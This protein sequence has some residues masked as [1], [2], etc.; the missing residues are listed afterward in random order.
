MAPAQAFFA[1]MFPVMS[2]NICEIIVPKYELVSCFRTLDEVCDQNYYYY[3][4]P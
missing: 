2:F 3:N 4:Q 1:S